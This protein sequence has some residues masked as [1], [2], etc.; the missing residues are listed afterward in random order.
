MMPATLSIITN[1]F[2]RARAGKAIGTWAGVSALALAIGP[3]VGGFLTEHVSWR[4][5][6]YLNMPVA[7]AA[8]VVTLGRAES[9][10]Q[11]VA[12]TRGLRRRRDAH[13]RNR[14]ARTG[15]RRGQPLGLGLARIIALLALSVLGPVAFEIVELR[16]EPDD[17]VR[18][19]PQPH[20]PGDQRRSR[21]S[22]RS[23]C[24]R[25]SSSWRSTCRTSS[26]TR[27]SRP[28]S[29][30]CPAT[31]MIMVARPDRGTAHRP[32][33]REDADRGRADA[34][35]D[36]ALP[37]I[38]DHGRYRLRPDPP[39]LHPDGAR[40]GLGDVADV[41]RGHELR[42]RDKAGAPRASSR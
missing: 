40:D 28:G 11:T 26:T 3:V 25:C 8:V 21:S 34:G 9:R 35:R 32:H 15:A 18:V 2:P 31:V 12:R 13:H 30:S 4:A 7:A 23:R 22:S 41:D 33:R 17:R 20:V 19:L 37:P 5:I 38:A 16:R 27:R 24:S 14:V 10:D 39:H 29:D 6:F 1:A 36:G 42:R